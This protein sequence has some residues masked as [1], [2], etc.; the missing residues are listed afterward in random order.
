MILAGCLVCLPMA[1]LSRALPFLVGSSISV[2]LLLCVFCGFSMVEVS[3]RGLEGTLKGM[4]LVVA[5]S[6]FLVAVLPMVF[7]VFS[8]L[9]LRKVALFMQFERLVNRSQ[10]VLLWSLWMV[11]LLGLAIASVALKSPLLVPIL[12]IVL[13]VGSIVLFVRYLGI[14]H[15]LKQS[16][17]EAGSTAQVH[18]VEGVLAVND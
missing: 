15:H 11:F 18:C 6:V 13:L 8:L 1:R 17:R 16:I 9:F 4:A 2:G 12:G 3:G 5:V 7:W 10:S 14:L